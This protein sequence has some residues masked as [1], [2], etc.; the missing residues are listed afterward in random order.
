MTGP[1]V[2]KD[3]NGTRYQFASN[4][5]TA[6]YVSRIQ[7]LTSE[8]DSSV[9]DIDSNIEDAQNCNQQNDTR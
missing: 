8:V 9:K 5:D 6:S 2:G 1:T 7:Q 3:E 4:S